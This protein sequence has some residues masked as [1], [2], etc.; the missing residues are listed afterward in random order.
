[1]LEIVSPAVSLDQMFASGFEARQA[2]R[3]GAWRRPTD[4]LAPE[5]VQG[6]VVILPAA[7]ASDFMRYCQAN[8]KP[9]PVLA[10][11]DVGSRQVPA[12][13]LDLDIATDVPRYV[14]YRD[15]IK[16]S[17]V[18]DVAALWRDDLVAFVLGCSF[19]FE[20]SLIDA[21]IPMRHIA[22]GRNVAMFD[23]NIPTHP[24]G[25]FHGNLVV[26]MRPM[27]AANAIRAIQITA[28]VPRVHGAPVHLGDGR[29]IGI[30]NLQ[31]PNY[32]DAVEIEADEI[33]VFWACGVTPQ[34]VIRTAKPSF[35]I[36]HAPGYM[37]ITDWL[38][39]DLP[40]L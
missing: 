36:T 1:M 27:T 28:R 29:L 5:Y 18:D 16:E 37:L 25:M 22:Q 11:G 3:R 19:S 8:P 15:G 21:G 40:Y 33:P 38:N 2:I 10:I 7:Q 32:G 12:L 35:C 4:G 23:T 20:H 17:E 13:G 31:R 14:V 30:E 34:A 39:R 6:N 9:C 24:A 26:S